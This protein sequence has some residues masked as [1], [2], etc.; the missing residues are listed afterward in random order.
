MKRVV[1]FGEILMRLS[2][3]GYSRFRQA[4]A[5]NFTFG[6]SEANVAASLSNYGIEPYFVTRIPHNEIGDLCLHFLREQGI[7]SQYIL[8][9][10]DRLGIYFLENGSNMRSSLV[11]YDRDYSSFSTIKPG[12]F[13][14]ESILDNCGWFHLSGISLSVSEGAAETCFEAVKV[15]QKMGIPVSCDI[16]Y[17]AKL[18]KWGKTAKE[19]LSEF[20]PYCTMVFGNEEDADK[21]F[22]I[23]A[24]D[25]NVLSGKVDSASYI[26][27]C[28]E[29]ASLFPNLKKV[30]FTLR[31]SLSAN[32]N[33]WNGIL[34]E[35]G[36]CYE[37]QTYDILDIVD[38]VGGGDSFVGGLIYGLLE[39]KENQKALDF[40]IAAS[41]LKHTILGDFNL[42][43]KQE[44]E[45]LMLGDASG[46]VSR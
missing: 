19:V 10:G 18:W 3:Q 12:M 16:N 5:F 31:S 1:T 36:Q 39:Y 2:P 15:A 45:K 32:H 24:P 7:G 43:S 41:A 6:G 37:G 46:R 9:G 40:A 14:W 28:N 8:R 25:T 4:N 22:G 42:V 44:V 11:V 21:V 29:L 34:W 33:L 30:A 13:D 35:D 26:T 27:V 20:L 17:R 38:R 23:S